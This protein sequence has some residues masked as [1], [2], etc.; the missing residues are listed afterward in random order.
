MTEVFDLDGT[1]LDTAR[2]K[3]QAF[4]DA[5]REYGEEAAALLR[6][7]HRESSGIPRREQVE[8]WAAEWF[9]EPDEAVVEGVLARIAAGLEGVYE[10]APEVPGALAYLRSLP[11]RVCVSGIEEGELRSILAARGI[12]FD[13]VA[14]GPKEQVFRALIASRV[15]TLPATYYGDTEADYQAA[16]AAG[17]RFVLVRHGSEWGDPPA[18]IRQVDTFRDIRPSI[19]GASGPPRVRVRV[20]RDGTAEVLGE[21]RYF[22]RMLAGALVTVEV[23]G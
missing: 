5:G 23:P 16:T 12:E 9:G 8:R 17:L 19:P 14:S 18:A 2:A 7:V 22:G 20:G 3:A 21:R 11:Y 13:H 15:I 1:I 4:Y 10:R 6:M